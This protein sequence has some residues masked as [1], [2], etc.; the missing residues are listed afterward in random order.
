MKKNYNYMWLFKVIAAAI[1]LA[2]GITM[3]FV[4]QAILLLT[5]VIIVLFSIIRVVPLIKT[6]DKEVLRTMNLF[7]I[8]IDLA[9]G[10]VMIYFATQNN[11]MGN[12]YRYLLATVLYIRGI[13][14]FTST[15]IF[16]E[17]TDVRKY[18]FHILLFTIGSMLFVFKEF[19]IE[20]LSWLILFFSVV[21]G[22]YIGYDGFNGYRKYRLLSTGKAKTN[23]VAEETIL[24][25][26]NVTIPVTDEPKKE[27]IIIQ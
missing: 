3:K 19:D 27:E 23:V 22:A 20:W 8:V 21:S 7:E 25:P 26:K 17:K 1:L 2:F 14:F 16:Q 12:M 10:G 9:I 24:D 13:V 5:G 6:L 11:E 18:I 4:P 15:V